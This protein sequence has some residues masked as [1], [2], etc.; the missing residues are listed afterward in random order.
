[1]S[2]NCSDDRQAKTSSGVDS[3]E[4]EDSVGGVGRAFQRVVCVRLSVNLLIAQSSRRVAAHGPGLI[5]AG[6]VSA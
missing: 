4:L 1:M 5:S 2:A 3:R 6:W